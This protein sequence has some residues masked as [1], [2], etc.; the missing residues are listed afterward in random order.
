[1]GK[2]GMEWMYFVCGT[3]IDLLGAEG[4]LLLVE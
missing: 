1:M 4:R 3:D 2:L